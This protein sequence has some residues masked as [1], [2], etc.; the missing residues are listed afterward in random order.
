MNYLKVFILI[1]TLISP[2]NLVSQ[3]YQ[4]ILGSSNE[5]YQFARWTDMD[6][7]DVWKT[8][9]D[10]II[11]SKLY[12]RVAT[13]PPS[14]DVR[15]LEGFIREDTS[16]RRVYY[17]NCYNDCDT[18]EILLYDFGKLPGDTVIVNH[19]YGSHP[20]KS[21]I[22]DS[23]TIDT[24]FTPYRM[25]KLYAIEDVN[26]FY[27]IIWIEGIGSLAGFE[28]NIF[29]PLSSSNFFGTV[30]LCFFKDGV[31]TF[32]L[33]LSYNVYLSNYDSCVVINV[34]IDEL[35]LNSLKIFPNPASDIINVLS[36]VSGYEI[37]NIYLTDGHG[38]RVLQTKQTPISISQS[39]FS[40]G[41]YFIDIWFTNGERVIGKI[42]IE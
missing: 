25:F 10:T 7:T 30:L 1:V 34:G 4:P 38:R 26:R 17:I 35:I 19:P 9:T 6:I 21:L 42:L 8:T 3:S 37:E 11:K 39:N 33:P 32:R 31:K 5:W 22:L 15:P 14:Y 23:I 40:K 18:S 13:F 16:T 24:G 12:K 2:K 28:N 41:L 27:P 29:E 20:L 36:N